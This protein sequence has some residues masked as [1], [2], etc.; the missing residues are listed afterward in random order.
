MAAHQHQFIIV[1]HPNMI[2]HDAFGTLAIQHEIELKL[3][4]V[5]QWEVEGG[6]F[7]RKNGKT[8]VRRQ[9]GNFSVNFAHR[10]KKIPF[11]ISIAGFASYCLI[12]WRDGR[13]LPLNYVP[14]A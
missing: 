8:I 12:R 1:D 3:L 6:F 5:V 4:M 14:T 11:T 9:R 2:A 13:C 7:P 10:D